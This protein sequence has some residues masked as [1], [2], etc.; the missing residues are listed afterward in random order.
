MGELE[1]LTKEKKIE[2]IS[3]LEKLEQQLN[4]ALTFDDVL[5]VPKKS[6]VFSRKDTDISSRLSKNISLTMPIIAANMDTVCESQ[7]AIAMAQEGGIGFIHRFMSIEQQVEEVLK[8]KRAESYLI[9]DP[10]T[11]S[12][13]ALLKDA[14]KVMEK[15]SVSS[16]LVLNPREKLVGIL[17]HRD[18]MFED[19]YSKPVTEVMTKEN[20]LITAPVG[21]TIDEAKKIL[22]KHKIEK[23]PLVDEEG[24]IKG[25][26]TAKDIFKKTSFPWSSTDKKGKLR[27]AAAIGVKHDFLERAEKLLHVGVDALVVDIAH[28]HSVLALKAIREIRDKL[29]DVELIAGNIAT[30]EGAKELIEAGVDAVKCGVGPGSTCTTRIVTGCGMPQLTAIKNVVKGASKYDIPVIA[31]GGI[32]ASGDITKALALG[33]STV[34]IGGLFAGTDES[35]GI[36]IVRNNAK[37]KICRGMASFTASID[38]RQNEKVSGRDSNLSEVVP[39]G[40][41]AIVPY[42]GSVKDI[43]KQLVGGLRSGIS[44]CG[45]TN[46]FEL[47]QNAEFVFITNSGMIESK[48]HDNQQI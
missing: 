26:I 17:T 27:V 9:E 8:V 28:G 2:S 39:E 34:M 19:D 3:I 1:A 18:V 15:N 21:T 48:S 16:L 10:I 46:L 4:L 36:P 41:E 47:K 31:D 22:Q 24:I 7:M 42:R 13:T 33:A 37:Y 14:F 11:I 20:E 30:E 43:L 38:R 6:V 29:G 23:L 44:Y 40:V 25:L 12:Q 35:P 5:L 32:K 45:A